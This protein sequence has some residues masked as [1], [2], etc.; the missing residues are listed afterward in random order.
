M[1]FK[2]NN[3]FLSILTPIILSAITPFFFKMGAI[4]INKFSVNSV[5]FNMFYWIAMFLFIL[6]TYTWIKVLEQ[7]KLSY[8]YPF[9]SIQYIIILITGYLFFDE[10]LTLNNI[11][12]TT[13]II[14]G[15]FIISVEKEKSNE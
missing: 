8:V 9:T 6:R 11:I 3:F 15:V 7:F 4:S 13:F 5:F 14:I 10:K 2:S 12:G 1:K